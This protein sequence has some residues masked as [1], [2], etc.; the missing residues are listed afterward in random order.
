[1]L[2]DSKIGRSPG[3]Y[4]EESFKEMSLASASREEG[5]V[6]GTKISDG[7]WRVWVWGQGGS[8]IRQ[9]S[10]REVRKIP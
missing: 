2:S 8:T 6:G 4:F 7:V 10:Q 1:M 3:I 9:A 5:G